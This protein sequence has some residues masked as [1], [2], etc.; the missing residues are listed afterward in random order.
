MFWMFGIFIVSC[1]F[2]H[3]LE[4]VTL[5]DP[6]YRLSGLVKL[7][8]A[9]VSVAT[10][11]GLVP[12]VP[13]ALAL[14]SPE[15]LETE[16]AER[17][18]AEASLQQAR[19]ELE[20]RVEERTGDLARA[21]EALQAEIAHREKA[22]E[23]REQLLAREQ[24]ARTDAETANRTKD[25]FLATLS[26]ELRTPLNAMLGWVH[27][28]RGGKVDA[29]TAARGLEVL[30]RN[31]R[32]QAQLID[33]L[34]DVSRIVS[35]KMHIEARQMD[36][37][38][39]VESALDAVGPAAEAKGIAVEMTV[40]EG[41]LV[42]SGD[43]TRL[44]QVVWNLLIN[45][46]KF[47]PRGGKVEVRLDRSDGHA[48]LTVRDNGQGIRADLLPH[49]FERF[50]Q[51]DSTSTRLH[52]GLGLGLAIV[53]HLVEMHGGT[54]TAQSAGEGQGACFV[55][56]LP[57]GPV[58]P[59]GGSVPTEGPVEEPEPAPLA[60]VHTLVVDDEADARDMLAVV[61]GQAG[62]EV[63][64]AAS[65]PEALTL[66]ERHKVDVLVSDIGMPGEDGYSLIRKLRARPAERGGQVPAVALTAYARSEDRRRALTAGFQLHTPKPVNPHEL[67]AV[68][69][70]LAGWR[71]KAT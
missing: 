3:L 6:V 59:N 56:H 47:T 24:R 49:I 31:T 25:D 46:V 33:D 9:A 39:V 41:G 52:G 14:R 43:P 57:I 22:R 53:R 35:G 51:G 28:I 50:R 20:H 38:A 62:A 19:V 13:R 10:V 65:S 2:T 61:L 42:L 71:G 45:A 40:P 11:A 8:T 23:E 63:T 69:K 30:E 7:I 32:A 58:E 4:V 27:L 5:F 37:A 21:N 1:G 29:A 34:L 60:G 68:V 12:L 67:V 18:R 17:R 64:T 48:E 70:T 54:V 66:L 15:A 55:V 26:H 44:Q 16:I 36:L